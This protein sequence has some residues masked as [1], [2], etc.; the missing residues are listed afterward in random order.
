ML[1]LKVEMA[2]SEKDKMKNIELSQRAVTALVQAGWDH[3]GIFETIEYISKNHSAKDISPNFIS[4][5]YGIPFFVAEEILEALIVEDIA[6]KNKHGVPT[7]SNNGNLYWFFGEFWDY[8][9]EGLYNVK[10]VVT[11]GNVCGSL[12]GVGMP[13]LIKN[14]RGKWKKIEVGEIEWN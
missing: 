14:F 6:S 2:K 8:E 10:I 1:G 13:F 9:N 7:V 5:A 4:H 3:S 12:H 11:N